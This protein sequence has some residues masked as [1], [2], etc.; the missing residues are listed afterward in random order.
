MRADTSVTSND[1]WILCISGVRYAM[2]RQTSVVSDMCGIVRK[3]Y[4]ALAPWQVAQIAREIREDL[5]RAERGLGYPNRLLGA[6]CDHDDWKSLASFL[7][8]KVA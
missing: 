1:M 2:G 6:K 7:E 8:S 4:Q 5:S 3:H